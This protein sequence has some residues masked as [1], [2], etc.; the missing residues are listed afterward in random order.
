MFWLRCNIALYA[1]SFSKANLWHL[2][3][4]CSRNIT[5]NKLL[6]VS[7]VKYNKEK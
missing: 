4:E 2:D 7:L 5:G 1:L 6:F 3:N